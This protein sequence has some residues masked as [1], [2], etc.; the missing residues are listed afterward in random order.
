MVGIDKQVNVGGILVKHTFNGLL[1][2]Y[3][4]RKDRITPQPEYS[5]SISN[6]NHIN[7]YLRE[8]N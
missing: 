1:A 8:V 4:I 7:Q 3:C 6:Y 2:T 5:I